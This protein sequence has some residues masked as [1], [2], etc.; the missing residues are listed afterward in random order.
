M[1]TIV[2]GILGYNKVR[3]IMTQGCVII[4]PKHSISF[5]KTQKCLEELSLL[6]KVRPSYTEDV[7]EKEYVIY[8]KHNS[9]T[10][11]Y[12]E[13]ICSELRTEEEYHQGNIDALPAFF[14]Y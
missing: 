13:L 10:N 4:Q 14:G 8:A 6:V 5:E 3:V 12:F 1:K 9:Q 7:Y 11:L 2:E